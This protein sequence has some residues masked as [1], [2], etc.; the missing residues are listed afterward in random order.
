MS[1]E[2][3]PQGIR[4]ISHIA[5]SLGSPLVNL[6]SNL[7]PSKARFAVLLA[8][9]IEVGTSDIEIVPHSNTSSINVAISPFFNAI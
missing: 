3:L 2:F 1:G 7:R 9:G 6:L 4:Q 8:P 5:E